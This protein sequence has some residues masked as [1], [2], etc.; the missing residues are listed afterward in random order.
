[1]ISL[2]GKIGQ[3]SWRP[4]RGHVRTQHAIRVSRDGAPDVMKS[5]GAVSG[6]VLTWS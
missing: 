6:N 3:Y 1:M 4:H 2:I 5:L